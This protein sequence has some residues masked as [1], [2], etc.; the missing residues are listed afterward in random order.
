MGRLFLCLCLLLAT[1]L[2]SEGAKAK[3]GRKDYYQLL[4]VPRDA[5][6]TVCSEL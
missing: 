4:E 5:G 3:P 2:S 1:S 6:G